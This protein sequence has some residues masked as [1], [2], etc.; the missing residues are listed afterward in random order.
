LVTTRHIAALNMKG[1]PGSRD[2]LLPDNF[3]L[4]LL[5]ADCEALY[6]IAYS[7]FIV[8]L[9]EKSQENERDKP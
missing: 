9:I 8:S 1:L 6:A 4:Y 3:F 5:L 2:K 7:L